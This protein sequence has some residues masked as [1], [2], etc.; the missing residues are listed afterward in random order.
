MVTGTGPGTF[1][2][3]G[4]QTFALADSSSGSNVAGA[5]ALKLTGGEVYHTDVSDRYV[6]P[7]L[8]SQPSGPFRRRLARRQLALYRLRRRRRRG[9]LSA[10]SLILVGIYAGA[11]VTVLRRTIAAVRR[12]Q[13]SDPLTALLLATTIA[14][15]ALLQMGL[16]GNWLEVTRVTFIAWALLAICTKEFDARSSP[17]DVKAS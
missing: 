2:S 4:W 13:L 9:R 1:S 17:P 15:F 7:L 6:E 10:V 3:R 16:L 14:F 11:F 5:Y 8:T 12:P